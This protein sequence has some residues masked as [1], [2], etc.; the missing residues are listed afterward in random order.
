[1]LERNLAGHAAF[2]R[3]HAAS[4]AR[5]EASRSRVLGSGMGAAGSWSGFSWMEMKDDSV[6]NTSTVG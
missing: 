4:P 6:K 1:M 5:P 2:L 3:R